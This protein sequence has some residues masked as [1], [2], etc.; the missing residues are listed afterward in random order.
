MMYSIITDNCYGTQYYTDT[1]T[2]YKT[3]FIGLFLFSPCYI[4]F[5]ENYNDYI[6]QELVEVKKSK[7]G[8]KCYPIGKIGAS[9]IQFLHEKTFEEAKS[10]WNRRRRRLEDFKKCIIK[11]CDRDLFDDK[12][13]RRFIKLDHPNKILF[14]SKKWGEDKYSDNTSV[15]IVK[16]EDLQKCPDGYN[17]YNRYPLLKYLRS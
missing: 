14:L 1:N 17:L 10:K 15:L 6:E 4:T 8:P 5:L 13:L 9:E 7:Y 12:I 16:T 3:P 2:E 11:M